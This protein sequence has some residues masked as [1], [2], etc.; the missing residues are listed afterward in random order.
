LLLA[1]RW[2]GVT[3]PAGWWLSE[4][5]DGVRAFWDGR[6]FFSRLGNPFHVPDWFVER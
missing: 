6:Q 3:D 5:L 4:K 2:D 1:E